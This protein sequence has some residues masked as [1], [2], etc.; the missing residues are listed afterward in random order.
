[1]E[2]IHGK[3]VKDVFCGNHHS[4]Y[5]NKNGQVFGWGLNNHGQLGIG[6]KENV[7]IPEHVRKLD[8]QN[9]TM[10]AGGEHHTIAVTIEGKVYCWG[11]NDEAQCG[12]GDLYG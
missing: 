8:G 3:N 6:H 11:R 7:S 9:V 10:M 2:K 4:F 1:M 12:L 5:I